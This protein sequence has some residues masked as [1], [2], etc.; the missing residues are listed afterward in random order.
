MTDALTLHQLIAV[1]SS[2]AEMCMDLE[3]EVKPVYHVQTRDGKDILI[4]VPPTR[5]K[6]RMMTSLRFM[7]GMLDATRYV[8]TVEAWHVKAEDE[9]GVAA[10]E[11]WLEQHNS[12]ADYPGRVEVVHFIA[13]DEDGRVLTGERRII[14]EPGQ[15]PR[16][17]M[18]TV[19]APVLSHGRMVGLL[20]NGGRLQ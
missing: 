7:L 8:G 18:L 4:P 16:L 10:C 9:R 2:Y 17:D 12:L 14:R 5:D 19:E 20:W 1:A 15:K 11:A 3:G 6:D 13:E